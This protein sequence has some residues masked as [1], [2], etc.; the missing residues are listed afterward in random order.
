MNLTVSMAGQVS[1][2]QTLYVTGL[3]FFSQADYYNQVKNGLDL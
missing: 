3:T 2:V 1:D